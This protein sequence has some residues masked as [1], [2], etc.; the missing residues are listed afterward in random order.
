[1]TEGAIRLYRYRWVILFI[2]FMITALIEIQWIMLAP[3]TKEAVAFYKVSELQIAFLSMIF[4]I[5]YVFMSVPASYIIDTW[6]IRTGIGIGA[7]LTGTFSL[8]KGFYPSSYAI[9]CV[10]Q[11]GLAVAQPFILN[12]TTRLAARWFPINERATAAGI[13][14]LG[15]YIGIIIAMV[16]TSPPFK[17]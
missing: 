16:A 9:L 3:V 7:I 14:T 12:A 4:M 5:V 13:S 11:T 8:L 2:F 1:M 6:G 10:S 17:T 15:Q